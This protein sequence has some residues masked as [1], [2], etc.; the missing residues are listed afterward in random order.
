MKILKSLPILSLFALS[1]T[2]QAQTNT[3]VSTTLAADSTRNATSFRVTSTTGMNAPTSG[4]PAS[5]LYVIDQGETIGQLV[6]VVSISG[7][8]VRFSPRGSGA[9]GNAHL[10]GA[11]ILVATSP[12]WFY[13]ANPSGPCD[14]VASA[15]NVPYITTPYLNTNTG[16]QWLC[17]SL[18][19]T[20]VPGWGNRTAPGGVTA[21]VASA[22]GA[23]IPSGP[24][25]HIT[26]TAAITG[27]TLPL[28]FVAGTFCAINDGVYTWTTA[29]NIATAG[30][31]TTAG[32]QTCFTW[33]SNA[34]KWY[35]NRLL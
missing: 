1:L 21:A 8:T 18:T 33:D 3:L 35:P 26:G 2:V 15:V 12:D 31:T 7:T 10:S 11:L 5:M 23:I 34:A 25:F 16:Q 19:H 30:T 17:S 20:W 28:G 9:N 14:G 13:T 29:G 27:F 22:A 6:Q 32:Q 4:I 24:L